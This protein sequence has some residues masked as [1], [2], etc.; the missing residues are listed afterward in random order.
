M[1]EFCDKSNSEFPSPCGVMERKL[2]L[3]SKLL[4][5]LLLLVSV[6][7][8]GNGAKAPRSGALF[9]LDFQPS[10]RR[11]RKLEHR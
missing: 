4:P 5:P 10:N 9:T 7:L 2:L 3:S 8:R 6:P 11:A 1:H